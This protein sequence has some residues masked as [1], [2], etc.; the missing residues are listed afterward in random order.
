[1]RKLLNTLYVLSEDAYLS[2]TGE[3]VEIRTEAGTKNIPL[4]TLESIVCFSYKG[5]SPAL[6]GKCA[7]MGI[8]LSFYDRSGRFLTAVSPETK[9]N[10]LLRRTQFRIADDAAGSTAAARGFLSGKLYNEKY[11]LLRAVRDHSIQVDVERLKAAAAQITACIEQLKTATDA[12]TLRGVEGK[13]AAAY[14]GVFDELIL[15]NKNVFSFRERSRRPPLDPINALLSLTY[16]VLSGECASA[17]LSVG[18]DPYVGFLHTD[19]PGRRSLALDLMEELRSPLADRFVLT[20]VNNRL[21]TKNDFKKEENG[22]IFLKDAGRKIF[23]AHCKM[24]M[25]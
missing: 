18:L 23:F 21:L 3:T 8:A 4:H 17:L 11:V 24:K 5:A 10:V 6:M 19:R 1:M 2:L 9:G 25:K 16:S 13:A 12:D 20:L 14:F 22:A 15:Q 7:E